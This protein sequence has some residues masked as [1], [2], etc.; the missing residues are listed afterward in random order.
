MVYEEIF[1][2]LPVPFPA[3][4]S[5]LKYA[6]IALYALTF[7][8][9]LWRTH[10]LNEN[11]HDSNRSLMLIVWGVACLLHATY[12]YPQTFTA[13]G[14]NL[15]FYNAVSILFFIV[16]ALILALSTARKAE[17]LGL[18]VLPIVVASI[19]LTIYRPEVAASALNLR[20]LQLHIV[21][22]LFAFSVLA[23][24]AL[25]SILL[26]TQDQ[27]LRKHQLNGMTRALPPL[28]DTEKFLFQTIAVGFI[29]LSAALLT[30]FLFL[31]NMFEQNVAYKTILSI[32]AWVVFALLLWGRWQ[33]GWRGSIAMRWTLGGFGFL[34]FAY[35]GSKFVQELIMHQVISIPVT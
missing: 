16:A 31:D 18:L 6:A 13:Q 22:S 30:G 15:T 10:N 35:L 20:G 19:A 11:E 28:H 23:I 34:F 21:T 29:L 27:H 2:A 24:S 33:F 25:Q 12:L 8:V 32:L 7:V 1:S 4:S 14:L 3:M 9:I 26:F 17:L 5:L